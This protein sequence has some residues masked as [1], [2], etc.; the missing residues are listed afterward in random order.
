MATTPLSS[1]SLP[2]PEGGKLLSDSGATVSATVGHNHWASEVINRVEGNESWS[3]GHGEQYSS[4]TSLRSRI[5]DIKRKF[6]SGRALELKNL[7]EGCKEQDIIDAFPD[8]NIVNVIIERND[9]RYKP[10][11]KIYLTEPEILDDW[12][13]SRSNVFVKNKEVSVCIGGSDGWLCVAK[14]PNTLTE[15]SFQSL[16]ASYGKVKEAFLMI[17]EKTGESKDYGL[18][19]YM[20]SDAAAQARHLLDNREIDSYTIDCD[21][22][23]SGRITFASLHSKCLYV[24]HL[25]PNYRDM[26]EFR[27]R[28]SVIKNPPYCQIAM[29]NGVIQNWGLVEFFDHVEAEETRDFMNGCKI[30]NTPIRVHY[31]IPGVNAINIYMQVVNAPEK[32]KALLHDAPSA[33]VYSQLQKLAKQNPSFAQNLQNIIQEQ[34]VSISSGG[35][36]STH[37]NERNSSSEVVVM[38]GR[39]QT[40]P[41]HVVPVNPNLNANAQA[42]LMILLTAQ[43]QS[44]TGEVSLLQNPQVVG[45]LQSLVS[46][47]GTKNSS[48]NG[49]GGSPSLTDLLSDPELS[50]D[51]P[52]FWGDAPQGYSANLG[53]KDSPPPL[54]PNNLSSLLNTQ[55]LSE[56]LGSLDPS[57]PTPT[58]NE[59]PQIRKPPTN[60]RPVLIQDPPPPAPTIYNRQISVSTAPSL[61]HQPPIFTQQIHPQLQMINAST[62]PLGP[63]PQQYISGIPIITTLTGGGGPPLYLGTPTT[64]TTASSNSLFTSPSQ[65]KRKLPI[66]PSPE[67]SPEGPYIGQHSQGL[68][69]HYADSY[70]RNKRSRFH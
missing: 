35:V 17:S 51:P 39:Q 62:F 13:K 68:G 23:N 54:I 41:P 1:S 48:S 33:N 4:S 67:Q 6:H 28:F 24:N 60:P 3:N 52:P 50:R 29:K 31:C 40:P 37:N 7:P 42:A 19:K 69:G 45:I 34:I 36:S 66:P 12:P 30:H 64:P 18:I 10:G 27:K 65:L 56:L 32:K 8:L 22:L 20:S 61:L 21:W 9:G 11:G 44:E 53:R 26:G 14:L 15:S 59:A 2:P 16:A 47:A 38:P 5:R 49:N 43:M 25:P 55:N 63:P 58:F 57:R 70:W 46:Q